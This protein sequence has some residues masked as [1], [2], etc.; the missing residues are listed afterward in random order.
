MTQTQSAPPPSDQEPVDWTAKSGVWTVH[1]E[2][3]RHPTLRGFAKSR[4]E[5]EALLSQLRG[6]DP[7][8][9]R[10]EYWIYELSHGSLQDFRDADMVPE[11]F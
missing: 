7:D 1:S 4:A 9:A 2:T 10:T 5:A 6:A 3:D 11:G 8:A